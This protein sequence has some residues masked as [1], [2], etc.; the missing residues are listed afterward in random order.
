MQKDL[1][2]SSTERDLSEVPSR[3]LKC[4][5]GRQCDQ[6]FNFALQSIT[7]EENCQK[8]A[9]VAYSLLSLVH[10]VFQRTHNAKDLEKD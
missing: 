6:F 4:V 3:A 7:N 2:K 8:I 5:V 9:I 10:G 1:L